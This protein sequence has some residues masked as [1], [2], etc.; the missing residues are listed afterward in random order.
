MK[1]LALMNAIR[2]ALADGI[3][4]ASA[5]FDA[6]VNGGTL[7]ETGYVAPG[8][9]A[10]G[11]TA[12]L[13]PASAARHVRLSAS[14][15]AFLCSLAS[16]SP[17]ERRTL[18][19]V[20]TSP[21][22]LGHEE[23]ATTAGVATNATDRFACPRGLPFVLWPGDAVDVWYDDVLASA[24]WRVDGRDRAPAEYMMPPPEV[25]AAQTAF[26][27]TALY[28]MD[29]GAHASGLRD[30]VSSAQDLTAVAGISHYGKWAKNRRGVFIPSAGFGWAANTILAPGTASYAL[31]GFFSMTAHTAEDIGLFGYD[32]ITASN[33]AYLFGRVK[34]SNDKITVSISD[35]NNAHTATV[36]INH[37]LVFGDLY[38]LG[39]YVSQTTDFLYTRLVNITT[40][41]TYTGTP[42]DIS[43]YGDITGGSAPKFQV[44]AIT[45][46]Y[47]AQNVNHLGLTVV[48]AGLG[49]ATALA[50]IMHRLGAG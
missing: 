34:T 50:N 35:F 5:S 40:G 18:E 21:I 2:A 8:T 42:L 9:L 19:N 32:D 11:E 43:A 44:G 39:F 46:R 41:T 48:K 37:A 31:V 13:T 36:E 6:I 25:F 22:A 33:Q 20:G 10:A 45:G 24:R 28:R 23:T 30:S 49:S 1:R 17:G 27:P 12:L 14:G 38:A 29:D 3:N 7:V 26:A 16:G 15:T 4:A 47:N